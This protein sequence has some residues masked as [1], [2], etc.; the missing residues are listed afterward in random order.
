MNQLVSL[1]IIGFL[2]AM[3]WADG[4]QREEKP[5]FKGVELYSWKE[6]EGKW[7]FA[8]LDGTNRLKTEEEVKGAKNRCDG[9]E[10]LR[11]ALGRLA[12]EE[13]V[14]WAHPIEGF[15]FPPESNRKEIKKAAEAAKINLT[16]STGQ[17]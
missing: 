15:E 5:R 7:V 9:V 4:S 10:K 8:L 12:V 17:D 1:L 3:S 2:C 13:Q 16:I 6:R 11:S 14:L